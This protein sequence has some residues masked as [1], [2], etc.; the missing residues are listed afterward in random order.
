MRIKIKQETERKRP[1]Q[2]GCVGLHPITWVSHHSPL[3]ASRSVSEAQ[4]YSMPSQ[5][6]KEQ[7][8]QTMLTS[9]LFRTHRDHA[10]KRKTICHN[11][12]NTQNI[13]CL[14]TT[15]KLSLSRARCNLP[16]GFYES[17]SIKYSLLLLHTTQ[18]SVS[19][20]SNTENKDTVSMP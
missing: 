8:V 14:S 5:R 18:Q 12:F 13:S 9:T 4:L 3:P 16:G 1:T 7:W 11:N 19:T 10:D 2:M 15:F 6:G 20:T 17:S